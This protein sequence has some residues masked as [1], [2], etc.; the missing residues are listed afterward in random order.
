[1]VKSILKIVG[2]ILAVLVIA[3]SGWAV[4]Q[5]SFI[6]RFLTIQSTDTFADLSWFD[7]FEVITSPETS[8]LQVAADDARV[9]SQEA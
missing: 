1:V 7:T 3:G 9:I 5:W 4:S 2:A 6:N 8:P